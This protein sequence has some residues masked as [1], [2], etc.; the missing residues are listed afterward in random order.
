MIDLFSK[1]EPSEGH[2][3]DSTIPCSTKNTDPDFEIRGA[4]LRLT[5]KG[6][7]QVSFLLK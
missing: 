6:R 2:L 7:F 3:G 1:L 5:P 4:N